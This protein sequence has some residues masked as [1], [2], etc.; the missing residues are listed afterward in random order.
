MTEL[1]ILAQLK[2]AYNSLIDILENS[3]IEQLNCEIL[4]IA[5]LDYLTDKISEIYYKVYKNIENENIK[6]LQ[7]E[8]NIYISDSIE[9]DFMVKYSQN[10]IEYIAYDE[11]KQNI[12]WYENL[13]N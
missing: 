11:T 4:D 10:D 12:K 7:Y 9:N 6:I 2:I 8:N 13:I 1:E 3:D 5:I